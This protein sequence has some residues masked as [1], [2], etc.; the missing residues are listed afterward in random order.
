VVTPAEPKPPAAGKGE[1]AAKPAKP[2]DAE[3]AKPPKTPTGAFAAS[4]YFLQLGVF[5]TEA[6]ARQLAEKVTA[7][8]FK[9]GVHSTNGQARVRVGPFSQRTDALEMQRKLKAKGFSTVLLGP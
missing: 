1:L 2:A 3:P 7:A 5:S 6:N 9:P 8:G 4:G